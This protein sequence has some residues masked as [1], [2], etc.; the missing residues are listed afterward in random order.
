M[1]PLSPFTSSRELS[2]GQSMSRPVIFDTDGVITDRIG[3][4]SP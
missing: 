2:A 4:C 3:E 1:T